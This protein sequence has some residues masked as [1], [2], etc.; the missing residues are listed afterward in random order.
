MLGVPPTLGL[1]RPLETLR[2]RAANQPVA[3]GRLH[4]LL[5]LRADRL[6]AGFDAR[7]VGSARM[8]RLTSASRY[9]AKEPF[10]AAAPPSLCWSACCSLPGHLAQRAANAALGETM[11]LWNKLMCYCRRR[12]PWLF[13]M[14]SGSCNGCDIEL[15]ASLTPRYDAEQLGVRLEGSPRH[16]DILCITG[17]VTHNA[18]QRHQDRL[19]PGL[20]TQGGGGHRLLPGHHQRLHRQPHPRWPA[21]QAYSRRCLCPRLPASPR[22]HHSGRSQG[23]RN[24]GRTS[25]KKLPIESIMMPLAVPECNGACAC[26]AMQK[27]TISQ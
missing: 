16:A 7:L 21:R 5:H 3:A 17:P 19:R 27:R 22:R 6:C 12:S 11:N 20:R 10:A 8:M 24:S 9:A 14:N 15:V 18:V 25:R 1:H 4:S 2:N 26:A 13:H 23:C